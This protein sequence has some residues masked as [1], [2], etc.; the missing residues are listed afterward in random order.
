MEKPTKYP[1]NVT[2]RA[3]L[4]ED[5]KRRAIRGDVIVF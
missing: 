4:N 2:I 3:K 5:D 1:L